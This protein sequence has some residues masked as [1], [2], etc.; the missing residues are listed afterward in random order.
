MDPHKECPPDWQDVT[1]DERRSA[2]TASN[3][4]WS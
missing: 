2:E 3:D 1:P 4:D